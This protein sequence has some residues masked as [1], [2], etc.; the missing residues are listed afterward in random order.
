MKPLKRH[1]AL[2]QLSM[3]HHHTL[4]LCLR[5]MR[6]PE[7]NHRA[8][9][10]EHF[11]DLEHHFL[12]EETLFGP[13][14]HKLPDAALRERFEAEHAQLRQMIREPRF[15][16]AEWNKAFATLL[17]SHARFEERELCEAVTKHALPPPDPA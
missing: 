2:T 13:L 11:V 4:A 5:I 6:E 15:D 12:E 9:I 3:E 7:K 14:W 16:D 1:P 10:T 17:R 8:D